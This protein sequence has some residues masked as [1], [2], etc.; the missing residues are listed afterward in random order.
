M[1]M[2]EGMGPLGSYRWWRVKKTLNAHKRL[3]IGIVGLVIIIVVA[4]LLVFGGDDQ[5]NEPANKSNNPAV[6]AYQK[7]LP[8]LKKTAE[9][10]PKDAAAHQNYAI[11][12]YA[13]GNIKQAK[14][15]YESAIKYRSNDATLYNNLGN[16]QRDLKEYDAAISSY[17]KAISLNEKLLNPY[18]NLANLQIYTLKNPDEG[19]ETY[20][21]ALKALPGNE[22]VQILLA[23]AYERQGNTDEA[24]QIYQSVLKANPN[25]AAAKSNLD[26][27][28]S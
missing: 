2:D 21:K 16:A 25:N 15:E 18:V 28:N 24:K 17:T 9:D 27:L 14:E 5:S 12:L 23:L 7:Q 11:A 4:S 1:Q 10:K 22:Q 13:T 8:D 3:V 19:I 26:R 6:V 20:Q